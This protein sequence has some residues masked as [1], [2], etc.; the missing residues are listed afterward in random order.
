MKEIWLSKRG[1]NEFIRYTL[2][3]YDCIKLYTGDGNYTRAFRLHKFWRSNTG[4]WKPF[5]GDYAESDRF[6]EIITLLSEFTILDSIN[7]KYIKGLETLRDNNI[8]KEAETNI[9]LFT[10]MMANIQ[11]PSEKE[12]DGVCEI[13]NNGKNIAPAGQLTDMDKLIEETKEKP[14]KDE[15]H[16]KD[17]CT[18]HSGESETNEER[19]AEGV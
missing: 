14:K 9:K 4:E 15:R 10:D 7:D 19:P 11:A 18:L 16:Q 2:D 13:T 3:P 12:V 17:F 8:R 1:E 5:G 6:V